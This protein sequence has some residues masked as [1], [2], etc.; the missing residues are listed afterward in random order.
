MERIKGALRKMTLSE[1]EKKGV[2]V[3]EGKRGKEIAD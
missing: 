1:A 2:R 3:K